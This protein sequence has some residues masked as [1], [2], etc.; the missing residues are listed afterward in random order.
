MSTVDHRSG[1]ASQTAT[2]PA[3]EKSTYSSPRLEKYGSVASI[4]GSK[5]GSLP[6]AMNPAR[7]A[8]P[9]KPMGMM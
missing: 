9:M 8:L 6:D 4:T 2:T 1:M 3:I 5:G 7:G